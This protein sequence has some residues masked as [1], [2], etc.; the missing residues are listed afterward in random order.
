MKLSESSLSAGIN[1][2]R[3]K[4]WEAELGSIG[5]V[6]Y[7]GTASWEWMRQEG[8][9]RK[10]ESV[11]LHSQPIKAATCTRSRD[12]IPRYISSCEG[13]GV[14]YPSL[15][16]DCGTLKGGAGWARIGSRAGSARA[17]ALRLCVFPRHP[18]T[19]IPTAHWA[20]SFYHLPAPETPFPP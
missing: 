19:W 17:M 10:Q 6:I 13:Y 15:G 8:E 1:A 18:Q 14:W 5:L 11:G 4:K 12:H 7:E 20:F 16:R 2:L 3:L 9:G